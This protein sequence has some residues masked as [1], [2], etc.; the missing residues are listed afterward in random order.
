MRFGSV[1]AH[2]LLILLL[3][4]G[5]ARAETPR[6]QP[7]TMDEVLVTSEKLREYIQNHPLDVATVERREIVERNLGSV[8]EIL[9]TMP[10]V[11]VYSGAGGG[12][13]ISIRGSGRSGGVL[14]LLNGRPLNSNQYG[15]QDLSSIPVDTIQ[16][17]SVFKPP[18]PVWLGPGGSEGAINIV[19]RT[20]KSGES[21]PKQRTSVKGGGGSYGLV[22]GSASHQLSMADSSALL[23]L[24]GNHRDGKR[25]NSDR[26][27]GAAGLNWSREGQL[28]NR[29]ELNGRYY[30]AEYGSPGPVDNETPDAR[31]RYGKVSLDARYSGVAGESGAV[32]VT[33]Y[34]DVMHQKD[35]AQAGSRYYLD[36]HKAGLKIDL[37]CTEPSEK[38]DLRVGGMTEWDEFEHTLS[39]DHER[40]RNGLNLQFDRRFGT[41]TATLGLRGDVT[42]DFGANP[43]GTVGLGWGISDKTLVKARAGYT[44]N[45]PTFEQLYQTSHGSIDQNRGN[46]DLKK[47]RLWSYEVGLEHRFGKDRLLQLTLFR[48]DATDL[49][50]Y[51]R[52]ADMIYRPVNTRAA[53][54]QG[55][56]LMTRYAWES[57]PALEMTLTLQESHVGGTGK[58]LPYTPVF[59]MKQTLSYTLPRLKTRLET[60]IRYEGSRYSQVENLPSQRMSDAVLVDLKAVQPFSMGGVSSE[61]YLKIDNLFDTAY[62]GHLGYPDDGI[63]A[64][65]GLQMRF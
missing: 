63:R 17:V 14:I 5:L 62:E 20:P 28:G 48:S 49:I 24:T 12:S 13:R 57:G 26:S 2:S 35:T 15:S 1:P 11:E 16:S 30:Q 50:T 51:R 19:T 10:G 44:V 54:R 31:Q 55:G 18:I 41:V 32:S 40:F 58:K 64:V 45:V 23:S 33:A 39:G 60:T 21:K 3:L 29:Y 43:G 22:E 52:G 61:L 8:E 47:E 46:P 4:T 53:V 42:N 38:W 7:Y 59:K 27:D 37:T 36:D 25:V 56:E 9:K 65:A 34:G 6:E